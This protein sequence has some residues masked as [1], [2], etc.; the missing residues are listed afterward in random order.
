MK[1]ENSSQELDALNPESIVPGFFDSFGL[2]ESIDVHGPDIGPLREI[3]Q[4][5]LEYS[6]TAFCIS[7]RKFELT[8]LGYYLQ[9]YNKTLKYNLPNCSGRQT[10]ASLESYGSFSRAIEEHV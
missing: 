1:I 9:I 4:S 8:K 7:V 2:D 10:L 6:A 5:V 3:A